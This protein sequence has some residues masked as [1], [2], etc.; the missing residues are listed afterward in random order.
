MNDADLE[1]LLV[2][3]GTLE[4]KFNGDITEYSLTLPSKSV[5]LSINPVTRDSDASWTIIGHGN[6]RSIPL[7]G[8][9]EFDLDIEVTAEDGSTKKYK[10]HVTVLSASLASLAD[11]KLSHGSLSPIFKDEITDYTVNL[12]WHLSSVTILPE[13]KDKDVIGANEN[14]DVFLNYGETLYQLEVMSPDKSFVKIFRIKFVKDKIIRMIAASNPSESMYCPI[15][16]GFLHCPVSIK[17]N[18]ATDP[19][20]YTYCRKC[21]DTVTRTRK[22]DPV[23]EAPLPI[24]FICEEYGTEKELASAKVFCCYKILGCNEE[25]DLCH[26]GNHMK[27][28]PMQPVV[29]PINDEVVSERDLEKIEKKNDVSTHLKWYCPAKHPNTKV[30]HVV[31]LRDWEKKLQE[32]GSSHSSDQANVL[33]QSN[34]SDLSQLQVAAEN[35]ACMIKMKPRNPTNHFKLAAVLEE[36]YYAEDIWGCKSQDVLEEEEDK[37]FDNL[38]D[39]ASDSSKEE[40]TRAICK[41]RGV[42]ENSLLPAVLKALDEEYHFLLDQSQSSKADYV[43]KLYEWKSAQAKGNTNLGKTTAGNSFLTKALLKF[44]DAVACDPNSSRY[45]MHVGRL[46]LMQGNY[47]DAIKRLE[48]AF[49]LKPTSIEARFYL[50]LAYVKQYGRQHSQHLNPLKYLQ[51]GVDYAIYKLCEDP[52]AHFPQCSAEIFVRHSNV[53]ILEGMLQLAHLFRDDDCNS[54]GGVQKVIEMYKQT[55]SICLQLM[56]GI[57]HRN[58]TYK[59][60]QWIALRAQFSLG[61]FTMA[62]L[63]NKLAVAS[64]ERKRMYKYWERVSALSRAFEHSTSDNKVLNIQRKISEEAVVLNPSCSRSLYRLGDAQLALYDTDALKNADYLPQAE[65]SYRASMQS[66]GKSVLGK[67]ISWMIKD[68][69]WWKERQEKER[70]SQ[71]LSPAKTAATSQSKAAPSP[72]KTL[73]KSSPAAKGISKSGQTT[74]AKS[75]TPLKNKGTVAKGKTVTPSK[76]KAPT[77]T[78]KGQKVSS[79]K[80]G[81]PPSTK[82][83]EFIKEKSSQDNCW[84]SDLMMKSLTATVTPPSVIL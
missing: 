72:L 34:S 21:L 75:P 58:K 41:S 12:P 50:G 29:A 56:N 11:I 22:I 25:I 3:P 54:N 5:S 69:I 62:E 18:Q 24:D 60:F 20:R 28:C 38:M 2:K 32:R 63:K 23:T 42:H 76:G 61:Q 47:E 10:V 55:S 36:M 57:T 66:E 49:G 26:L 83:S 44:L 65:F 79:A 27:G 17:L 78:N 81:V 37:T 35:Y 30:N 14:L 71:A 19:S 82:K 6:V 33:A 40:E 70:Q 39:I 46:L 74:T 53:L 73:A 68:S 80:S 8:G 64:E 9:D 4:P 52:D 31:E 16:L 7:H 51:A 77:T 67:E 13:A 59:D 84:S 43:Q 45:H 1:K 15:C 48:A